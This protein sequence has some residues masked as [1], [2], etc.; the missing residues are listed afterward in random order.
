[1]SFSVLIVDDEPLARKRMR[2]LLEEFSSEVEI[3]GEAGSGAAA[4][5]QIRELMPDVV[6]LDIQMPDMDGF[7]VL[8]GLSKEEVPLVVFTT[9][10]DNFA[11]KAFEEDTVDYLLKPVEQERLAAAIEKVRRR[12]P[13]PEAEPTLPQD[14][15]WDKL[16]ELVNRS[17]SYIQRLQIKIGDRIV[18]LNLDEV[19]R[20]QSEEKYTTVYA[21][22]GRYVIDTPLI[23]LEKKLDPRNFVKVHRSHIVAIDYIAECRKTEQGK[24][25]MILKDKNATQLQV[26]RS[27]I[28]KF[29]NL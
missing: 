17:D 29:R 14:F 15:D 2:I 16:R 19:I 12:L 5:Q 9:A 8:H 23:E 24:M 25:V 4:I 28:K 7:D 10:Y 26:S 27:V 6:F 11:V 20:F 22:D 13:G 21:I 1:M 18:F 3:L